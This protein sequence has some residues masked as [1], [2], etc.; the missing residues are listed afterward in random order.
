MADDKKTTPTPKKKLVLKA[1]EVSARLRYLR[2]SPRKVRVIAN[3]IKKLPALDA[4]HYLK[5]VKKDASS[6][7]MKLL[8]S[9]LANGE[10]NFEMT[11][12]NL[13]IKKIVVNQGPTLKRF[14]PRAHGRASMI[15]KRSSHIEL[16]LAEIKPTELKVKKVSKSESVK[17]DENKDVKTV[18]LDEVKQEP[19]YTPDQTEEKSDTDKKK[20]SGVKRKFFSRKVG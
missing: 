1:R 2:M 17:K 15:R 12:D 3:E 8:D 11:K 19:V 6:P 16:I 10:H 5:L 20:Q 18:S 14:K 4:L 7:I 9:A 13:F